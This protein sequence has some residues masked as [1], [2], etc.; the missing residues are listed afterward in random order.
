MLLHFLNFFLWKTENEY[1]Y[2]RQSRICRKR[3]EKSGNTVSSRK[4][5]KFDRG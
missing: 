2:V 4:N 3:A 5:C 1:L